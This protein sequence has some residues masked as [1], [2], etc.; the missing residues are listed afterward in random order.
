MTLRRI[1]TLSLAALFSLALASTAAAIQGHL[2]YEWVPNS[3]GERVT[4]AAHQARLNQQP[5]W[6][7]FLATHG[8][9]WT[10][11]WDEA[12][13]R[14]TRFWGEGIEAP[15]SLGAD[16]TALWTWTEDFFHAHPGL[17]G[18]GVSIETLQR[19]VIDRQASITTVSFTQ[20]HQGIP[21][22]GSRLSLRFKAG[23][24]VMGQVESFPG[25]RTGVHPSISSEKAAELATEFLHWN[26][27]E[28]RLKGQPRLI[29]FPLV[30]ETSVTYHLAWEVSIDAQHIPSRRSAYIDAM[31]GAGL[32][33][34]EHNRFLSG[35][36]LAEIDD[37]YP[38]AGQTEV[39]LVH[40]ELDDGN[41]DIEANELGEFT[42][43]Q[44]EPVELSWEVGSDY[45]RIESSQAESTVFFGSLDED[46]GVIVAKPDDS[47]G[48]VASRRVR[49]ELDV[50]VAG[51]V[52]R[53][54]ALKIDPSFT[55]GNF[56]SAR[57]RA[58][59]NINDSGCNAFFDGPS[60]NFMRQNSNCNNT[61]R[62]ADVM[63][64]EYGHGF[65]AYSI[66]QGAGDFDGALSEGL[67]DYLSATITNDSGMGRNFFLG[68]SQPL[69]DIGPDRTWPD[70]IAS[71]P[72]QTGLIIAG[73]LWDLRDLLIDSLG[74]VD[75][76]SHADRIFW[77]IAARASS[78]DVSYQEALLAD[79]DNG[80][81]S[82][83]TPNQC[84]ID[85]AFNIHGIGPGSV[86]EDPAYYFLDHAWMGVEADAW[87]D[88]IIQADAALANPDCTED[89]LDSL[90]VRF[91][92]DPSES[93][94]DWELQVMNETSSG[95]FE[96]VLP[97]SRGGYL[98]RYRIEALNDAG[99]V[100][101]SQ[102]TGSVTDPYLATWVGPRDILWES[103]FESDD[104]GFSHELLSGEDREGAD[105][106]G[107]GTPQGRSGDPVEAA[108]GDRA[109][110]N[111]ITPE[112]N[113]NG[114]Y[115]ADIHNVLR[116]GP[117]SV[118]SA[119]NVHL[120]FRRWVT[121]EDGFFDQAW[122]EVNGETIWSN[123]SSS[124]SD[125]ADTHH[126]DVHWAFRSY[127]VSDLIGDDG[128]VEIEWHLE[129]DGGLEFGGWNIDDVSLIT[130]GEAGDP[131]PDFEGDDGDD[132]G[133]NFAGSGSG[134]ACTTGT[135]AVGPT[136]DAFLLLAGLFLLGGLR[137]RS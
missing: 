18:D 124:D 108:S 25:I 78:I 21:V 135:G 51:H 12:T 52:A 118:G 80:N 13:H 67:A 68:S 106:W 54:R 94:E 15:V 62:I 133:P 36:V 4:H 97:G 42:T 9:L 113:W 28:A 114:A 47:L 83:G 131:P 39:P 53:E 112:D 117:L 43:S 7:D 8:P 60:V 101:A 16:D 66:I 116:S 128:I 121:V 58:N 2:P 40:V 35:V 63:Y 95:S 10:A 45:W 55:W 65:H 102:P 136:A 119:R 24:M 91:S 107:L 75:G 17:L 126:E 50:H 125:D 84:A 57:P 127:D 129:S 26:E 89:S 130:P 32:G 71:D 29:I 34:H 92:T 87:E 76:V 104:G 88:V 23:R 82:D 48:N 111:D 69:R 3:R 56:N 5:E 59:V 19:A 27:K 49:A 1:V 123:Y 11:V 98:L 109:W 90:V 115:Q 31:S 96:G 79:D 99:E 73:A 38:L 122:V 41:S 105:D 110:G 85:E 132:G 64:H 137:R 14:P 81:L 86:S 6:Q 37:R 61:G 72:H 20:Q 100:V 134:C 46:G 22:L 44:S 120:Q 74:E 33:W 30:G 70:D 93:V 77:Q 103:D